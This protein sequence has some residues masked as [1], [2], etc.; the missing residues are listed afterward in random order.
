MSGLKGAVMVGVDRVRFTAPVRVGQRIRGSF[1]FVRGHWLA[2][3]RMHLRVRAAIE[4]EGEARPALTGEISWLCM[5]HATAEA[6]R[7]CHAVMAL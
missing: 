7:P 3:D 6:H 2:P 1:H 4:V 5:L